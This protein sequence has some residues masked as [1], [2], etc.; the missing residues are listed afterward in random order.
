MDDIRVVKLNK[1][2]QDKALAEK[3]VA[4]GL[5]TPRD[6]KAASNKALKA[7]RGIGDGTVAVIRD[8]IG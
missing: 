5:T 4:A 2:L 7:I 8:R 3:L 6:I 1:R